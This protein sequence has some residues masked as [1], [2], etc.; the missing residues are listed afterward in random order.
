MSVLTWWFQNENYTKMAQVISSL[1]LGILFSPFSY[2]LFFLFVFLIFY[3]ILYYIFT[4]GD[5][6]YYDVETRVGV[7][8]GYI[9]GYIIGK[10]A[11]GQ[12]VLNEGVP[13]V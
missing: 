2:G 3:E 12:E 6:K 5:P 8:N 7:I 1:V 4:L 13:N 9:L 10:T 11:T